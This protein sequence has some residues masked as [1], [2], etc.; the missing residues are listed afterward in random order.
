[1]HVKY[2]AKSLL[3]SMLNYV[4]DDKYLGLFKEKNIE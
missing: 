3:I 1:M 4:K 2:P